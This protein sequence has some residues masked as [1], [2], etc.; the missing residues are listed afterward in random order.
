MRI[1]PETSWTSEYRVG[2]RVRV[3]PKAPDI[4]VDGTVIDV[5]INSVGVEHDV[6]LSKFHDCRGL[7]KNGYGY[8]YFYPDLVQPVDDTPL[9]NLNLEEGLL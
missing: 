8:W 4:W 2:D 9:V 6:S 7:C 1:P 3:K 5:G